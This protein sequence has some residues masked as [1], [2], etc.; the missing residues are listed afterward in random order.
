MVLISPL[1]T[2]PLVYQCTG[3]GIGSGGNHTGRFFNLNNAP[4]NP[5]GL[6]E[7]E[8]YYVTMELS[9]P[10]PRNMGLWFGRTTINVNSNADLIIPIGSTFISGNLVWN[11]G[12]TLGYFTKSGSNLSPGW[13]GVVT[14]TISKGN[15]AQP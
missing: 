11:T 9:V 3:W 4:S 15:C 10:I 6:V 7:G 13:D 8:T 2:L 5:M 14:I 1:G 12:S